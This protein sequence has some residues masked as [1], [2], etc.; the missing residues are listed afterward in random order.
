[1]KLGLLHC[2]WSLE[3]GQR[4]FKDRGETG[5]S[6]CRAAELH[7]SA[8][9]DSQH[10]A[11]ALLFRGPVWWAP[12]QTSCTSRL[13]YC[14]LPEAFEQKATIRSYQIVLGHR[15]AA[16]LRCRRLASGIASCIHPRVI[17]QRAV[18]RM[19]QGCCGC[20]TPPTNQLETNKRAA[21]SVVAQPRRDVP[22]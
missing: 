12:G 15:H 5:E 22:I 20:E 3:C 21:V 11:S 13:S 17:R 6:W 14:K 16:R 18:L 10:D 2:R 9:N 7:F 8:I 1:M 19:T 4:G